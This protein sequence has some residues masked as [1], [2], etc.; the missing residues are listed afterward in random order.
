MYQLPGLP[1]LQGIGSARTKGVGGPPAGY[2]W[3]TDFEGNAL[4]DASG[5]R[6]YGAI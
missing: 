1:Q 4:Y 2:A 6:L 3:L 5:V